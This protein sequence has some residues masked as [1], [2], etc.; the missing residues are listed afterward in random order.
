MALFN[1]AETKDVSTASSNNFQL[2]DTL[3]DPVLVRDRN[4]L[5]IY[6]NNAAKSNTLLHTEGAYYSDPARG[7]VHNMASLLFQQKNRNASHQFELKLDNHFLLIHQSVVQTQDREVVL[8]ETIKDRTDEKINTLVLRL[9]SLPNGRDKF[10]RYLDHLSKELATTFVLDMV[11]I[12]ITHPKSDRMTT[13]SCFRHGDHVSNFSFHTSNNPCGRVV[14]LKQ[15]IYFENHLKTLFPESEFIKQYDLNCFYGLPLTS[16]KGFAIGII[17]IANKA[18]FQDIPLLKKILDKLIPRLTL[19]VTSNNYQEKL[20]LSNILTRQA[21]DSYQDPL[22]IFDKEYKLTDFN[23]AYITACKSQYNITVEKGIFILD[24]ASKAIENGST[25]N[26]TTLPELKKRKDWLQKAFTGQHH[27]VYVD[28]NKKGK[29][30][31][32]AF[33]YYPIFNSDK[34]EVQKVLLITHNTTALIQSKKELERVKN[35]YYSLLD[36]VVTGFGI[37]DSI[38]NELL[39]FND[40]FLELFNIKSKK[41]GLGMK[42]SKL[43]P[44]YQPDGKFSQSSLTEIKIR[45]KENN[46]FRLPWTYRR[47]NGTEFQSE[48][49]FIPIDDK[50]AGLFFIAIRDL[51]GQ[52][53]HQKVLEQKNYELEQ[54]IKSN[55]QLENLAYS[56][57]HDLKEPLRTIGT[58]TQIIKNKYTVDEKSKEYMNFIISGVTR[59]SYFVDGLFAYSRVRENK[60]EYETFSLSQLLEYVE[61][62]LNMNQKKADLQLFNIP[63]TITAN[64]TKVKQL[65][66]NM[67]ANAIKFQQSETAPII[68]VISIDT[69]THWNFSVID[70][71]IGIPK[72]YHEQI[73]TL[74]RKLHSKDQYEGSGIGLALCKEIID[75]HK[76]EISVESELNKG[77]AFHFSI[78]K[79]LRK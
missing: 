34:T 59:M 7:K 65:F 1:V 17:S 57:C 50:Q 19:E 58:F 78:A 3:P 43:S 64:R 38:K 2:Y 37:Y 60:K 28:L 20:E 10:E 74:F 76:G 52:L 56:A 36:N 72:E 21:I 63:E 6:K 71:G 77:T 35:H 29:A 27:T 4:S 47:L 51:T 13:L 73:F 67:I 62:D 33:S 66:Q 22:C 5:L 12:A 11:T 39:D 23:K 48:T 41:D 25:N 44:E 49:S 32:Y 42:L 30:T 45:L 46:K 18:P 79:G 68:K 75:Q 70:N 14:D 69:P 54:Y 53:A 8:I 40:Q 31:H 61:L 26:R 16:E 24:E 9:S 15:S 55:R